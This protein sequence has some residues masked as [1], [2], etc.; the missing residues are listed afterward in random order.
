MN[1]QGKILIIGDEQLNAELMS[2][3][4]S[5]AGF[6]VVHVCS[7]EEYFDVLDS[8]MPD[9]ILVDI[10]MPGPECFEVARSL[11]RNR[12]ASM[13]PTI[14]VT[15]HGNAENTIKGIESGADEFLVRPVRQRELLSSVRSLMELK[16]RQEKLLESILKEEKRFAVNLLQNISTPIFV[17]DASHKIII[18]NKACEELTG[19]KACDML[20]EDRQWQPFYPQP[21]PTLADMIINGKPDEMTELFPSSSKSA[22]NPMGLQSEGWFTTRAGKE[23][24]LFFDAVPIYDSEGKL[25][26]VIESLRDATGRKKAEQELLKSQLELLAQHEQL[27]SLF[28]QVETAKQEWEKTLDCMGDIVILAD[29]ENRIRRCNKAL[30]DFAGKPYSEITGKDWKTLLWEHAMHIPSPC[31]SGTEIHNDPTGRWFV[32]NS[33]PFPGRAAEA[34]SVITIH[35]VTE[36]KRF[37]GELEEA[38]SQ[39]K[40]AQTKVAQQEKLACIG[41]IA[42]GIAHEINTPISYI[43]SN[44]NTFCGYADRL[45]EFIRTQAGVIE[46]ASDPDEIKKLG[47]LRESLKI[48]QVML[49]ISNLISE[50]LEGVDR[51]RN[52]VRNL[53]NFS[54]IDETEYK[55]ADI[56]D[57][58]KSTIN[59]VWN[60][61]KYKA[62]ITEDLGRIPC[63]KCYPQLLNQVFLNLLVNAAQSIEV[64]GEVAVRT[65]YENGSIF[66]SV[67]DTG[68]G[69]DPS[70]IDRIFEPFFTTKETGKGTGLGLSITHDI[71]RKHNGEILVRSEKGKGTTFTVR[72]PV[73]DPQKKS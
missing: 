37:T 48:D 26:A 38:F 50:S 14:L 32:I 15:A 29:H 5:R 59:I 40:A 41:E 43:F 33:H 72:L 3:Y 65:W 24:Y 22:V 70:I 10:S 47:E 20:G 6:E 27:Q 68:C 61:L 17:L 12:K 34:G 4:L 60:E 46:K 35:D 62:T 49:D 8:S 57:C 2:D 16:K 54:R 31:P 1:S 28:E 13:I 45:E 67:S 53:R 42:A 55:P 69:I 21:R 66:V 56:N 36:I 58:I 18:W 19:F 51:V 23:L 64:Q 63:T 39:L 7:C 71:I 73:V 52:I 30:R 25:V 44:L 9:I 11:K